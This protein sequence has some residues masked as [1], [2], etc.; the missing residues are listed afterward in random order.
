MYSATFTTNNTPLPTQI[1]EDTILCKDTDKVYIVAAK[2]FGNG[3]IDI[4]VYVIYIPVT[5]Q[6]EYTKLL[7]TDKREIFT[8]G[9]GLWEV[10][11]SEASTKMTDI[12]TVANLNEWPFK[13]IISEF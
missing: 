10:P 5:V 8:L 2:E 6:L 7:K 3:K 1:C 13:K 12:T 9:D 11:T 4:G